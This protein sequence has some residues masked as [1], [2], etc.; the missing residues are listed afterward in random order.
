MTL[1]WC[2]F[3]QRSSSVVTSTVLSRIEVVQ[4]SFKFEGLYL[5]LRLIH[6]FYCFL[7]HIGVVGNCNVTLGSQSAECPSA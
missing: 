3:L 6:A 4:I 2:Q 7:V 1:S 5:L